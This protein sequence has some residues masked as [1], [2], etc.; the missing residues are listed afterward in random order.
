TYPTLSTLAL[1]A[2]WLT[3]PAARTGKTSSTMVIAIFVSC[4]MQNIGLRSLTLFNNICR[5]ELYLQTPPPHN[6]TS[7]RALATLQPSP[8]PTPHDAPSAPVTTSAPHTP[9]LP[10]QE[11]PN[12]PTRPSSAHIALPT[13]ATEPK[14][15]PAQ[16]GPRCR[17][18]QVRKTCLGP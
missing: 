5:L 12:A 18:T 7:A 15:L 14:T 2:G 10:A 3:T 9:A 8:Q 1:T 13:Q 4:N 6:A 17:P 16:R 11:E